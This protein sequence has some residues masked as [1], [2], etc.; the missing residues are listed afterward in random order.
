MPECARPFIYKPCIS[1]NSVAV[2]LLDLLSST[3]QQLPHP[4]Y[5]QQL[6]H[7]AYMQQQQQ[8]QQWP[9]PPLWH[10]NNNNNG[11]W[12]HNANMAAAQLPRWQLEA[13]MWNMLHQLP[14]SASIVMPQAPRPSQ[15]HYSHAAATVA[16]GNASHFNSSAPVAAADEVILQPSQTRTH[17]PVERSEAVPASVANQ[18]P[19]SKE[20]PQVLD[21]KP[22]NQLAKLI[23]AARDRTNASPTAIA[24]PASTRSCSPSVKPPRLIAPVNHDQIPRPK[25]DQPQ[26]APQSRS[27]PPT[28]LAVNIASSAAVDVEPLNQLTVTGHTALAVSDTMSELSR[29]RTSSA[30]GPA[31]RGQGNTCVTRGEQCA[32]EALESLFPGKKFAKVRPNWLTNDTGRAMEID[33]YC[34]EL[35]LGLEHSGQSHYVW[36]NSL[37]KNREEF[38]RQQ[39]RDI[40]KRS[41]CA[42]EGVLLIEVPFTVPHTTM[43][44]YIQSEIERLSDEHEQ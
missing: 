1:V 18:P 13:N 19:I 39:R 10:I 3:M 41:L 30:S 14:Q 43:K 37:H 11:N 32:L 42:R 4:A 12:L 38:E 21:P 31:R 24:E 7:P 28:K 44:A 22:V 9:L 5:M 26:L 40:L 33:L 29:K 20:M 8:Q 17:V 15:L 25:P 27:N 16:H 36:P 23:A 34:H 6:A 2:R 35:R